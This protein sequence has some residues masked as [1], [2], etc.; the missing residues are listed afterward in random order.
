MAE[1]GV[2]NIRVTTKAGSV[3]NE[4]VTRVTKPFGDGL[5]IGFLAV[6]GAQGGY[7][8]AGNSGGNQGWRGNGCS[9]CR[10]KGDWC[11]RCYFDEFDC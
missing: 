11:D 6:R 1:V 8:R 3:K 10:A 5:V 9:T 7:F 4:T 2:G